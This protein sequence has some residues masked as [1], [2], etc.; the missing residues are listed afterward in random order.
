MPFHPRDRI[1]VCLDA[2]QRQELRQL[3]A[4]AACSEGELIRRAVLYLLLH[5]AEFLPPVRMRRAG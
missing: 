5:P 2:D 1:N 3:A 4:V